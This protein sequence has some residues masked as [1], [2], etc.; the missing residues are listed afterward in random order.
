L[1]KKTNEIIASIE[2]D[3]SLEKEEYEEKEKELKKFGKSHNF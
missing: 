1:K 3:E 2:N